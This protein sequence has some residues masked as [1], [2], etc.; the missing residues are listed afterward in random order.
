MLVLAALLYAA[1]APLFHQASGAS[2]HHAASPAGDAAAA[3][4]EGKAIITAETQAD[5]PDG[6]DYTIRAVWTNDGHPAADATVTATPINPAG[7][8]GTI[9]MVKKAVLRRS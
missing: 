7:A 4:H 5:R 1:W 2:A 3:A 9:S 6:T 8:A